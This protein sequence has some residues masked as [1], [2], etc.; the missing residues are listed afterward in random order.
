MDR[1]R[2][3]EYKDGTEAE[4]V[5]RLDGMTDQRTGTGEAGGPA[6]S[7]TSGATRGGIRTLVGNYQA[8]GRTYGE[9]QRMDGR[10]P[11]N[12]YT[13]WYV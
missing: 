2:E 11:G 3:G 13:F 9:G 7:R 6:C 4:R 8:H 12:C 10:V 1:S 5:R